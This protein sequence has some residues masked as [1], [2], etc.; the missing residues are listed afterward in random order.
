MKKLLLATGILA[1]SAVTF[2]AA[3]DTSVTGTVPVKAK[4]LKALSISNNNTVLDF[5]VMLQGDTNVTQVKKGEI[6]IE[7]TPNAN[8]TVEISGDQTYTDGTLAK[9]PVTLTEAGGNTMAANVGLEGVAS[10]TTFALDGNGQK[11]FNVIGKI[12]AVAGNQ[13]FGEYTGTLHVKAKYNN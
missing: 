3:T 11:M 8:I 1:L 9:T 6:H 2:G 12:P 4:V 5:G 13:V 10:E 7:G